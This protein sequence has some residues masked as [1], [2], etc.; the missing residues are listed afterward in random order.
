MPIDYRKYPKNWKTEIRPRILERA[1]NKCESCGAENYGTHPQ[2]GSRVILTVAHLD[3]DVKNNSDENLKAMCQKCHINHDILEHSRNRAKTRTRKGTFIKSYKN[4]GKKEGSAHGGGDRLEPAPSIKKKKKLGVNV[5]N[6]N[7]SFHGGGDRLEP[8]PSMREKRA[9]KRHGGSSNK[10][11]V[12]R[13]ILCEPEMTLEELNHKVEERKKEGKMPLEQKL[14][15][16]PYHEPKCERWYHFFLS[17]GND[18]IKIAEMKEQEHDE[19]LVN[20]ASRF[21]VF[22]EADGSESLYR[23]IENE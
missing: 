14:M 13:V 1:Q 19:F 9:T 23:R 20:Q 8:A 12:F 6:K 21:R 11:G 17:K 18:G 16:H 15:L 2:T 10:I 5:E 7:K 22:R 3:H 4:V